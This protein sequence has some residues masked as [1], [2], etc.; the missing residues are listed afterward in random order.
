MPP[1]ERQAEPSK[2]NFLSWDAGEAKDLVI[3]SEKGTV[4]YTHWVGGEAKECVY[5]GCPLCDEGHRR[6]PRWT[7]LVKC[8]N[9]EQAWEMSNTTFF[10]VEDSAEM[11]GG[12]KDLRLRVTRYGSGLKTR[13]SVLPIT[14][15]EKAP[16]GE[17]SEGW[18]AAEIK[19][20][21]ALANMDP[22]Q[23]LKL[24]LTKVQPSISEAPPA[25]QMAA[26]WEYI[27]Q[28]TKDLQHVD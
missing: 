23:E 8:E 19:R 22:K 27:N 20:L 11:V 21:C 24:F 7:V 18:Y 12:L 15:E 3:L 1:Y 26:F 5:D 16:E 6:T 17:R 14:G 10:G 2:G 25:A 13:Y 28:E 4:S 9:E